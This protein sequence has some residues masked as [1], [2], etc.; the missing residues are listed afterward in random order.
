MRMNWMTTAAVMT[1]AMCGTAL[2]QVADDAKAV[3]VESAKA[4]RS[5]NGV[6]FTVK[7]SG[8]GM[9]KDIIDSD[10][11]VKVW[12][13][14]GATTTTWMVDGRVKQP[15]KADKKMVMM[16]DGSKVVWLNYDDNT[17]YERAV[18][19]SMASQE[20]A[21]ANQVML[22]EWTMATPFQKEMTQ[23]AKLMKLGIDNVNGE[24][25]DIVEAQPADGSRNFTW[26]I[27]VADKLPRRLEMGTGSN[28]QKIAMITEMSNLK[29]TTFTAK[30]FEIAM[31][32]G[33]VKSGMPTPVTTTPTSTTPIVPAELG[34]KPGTEAPKFSVTD[35]AGN[36]ITNETIKGHVT[37]LEFWGT[38]F[39][40][41]TAN[42]ADMKALQ[43]EAGD[44]VKMIGFACRE[45]D[46]NRAKDWWTKSGLSY[47]LV[48]KGDEAAKA[49]KVTGFP[50]YYVIGKDGN[51]A[52]FFQDYPGLEKLKAAVQAASK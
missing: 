9:L 50:S 7:K 22:P 28:A 31:P 5:V 39:K 2:G 42:A 25:C 20:V 1:L 11:T 14:D 32:A 10:G 38:M 24:V 33:F 18:S 3:L 30:D 21:L 6:T 40:S 13:P 51:V 29:Q 34:L 43:G 15:G 37:V 8:T 45:L 17:M 23:F 35:A 4:I 49:F 19:D 44:T 36:S 46:E 48:T 26:A 52:A 16:T 27:S 41:S 47:P 12:R